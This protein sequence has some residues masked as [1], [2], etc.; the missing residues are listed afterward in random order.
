MKVTLFTSN[1]NR[2]NYFI[3]L[4]SN[5][6]D[7]LWVVQEVK[8]LFTGN[9]DSLYQN[10][11][12]IKS[13]FENVREVQ[14]KIFE[15]QHINN[16]AKNIKTLP[17]LNG[18]LSK[19]SIFYLKEF[20]ESNLYI[21][22]GSSYIKGNL[23]DFLVANKAINIHAGISPFYRGTDC[24]FWALYDNNPHLVGTTIHLLSKGLDSGAILYHAISD[25]K[26]NPYEYSMSSL[27]AAFHS[28]VKRIKD[29]SIFKIKPINQDKSKEIRYTRKHEFNE[30]IVKDYLSKKI[31]L[32]SKPFDNSL[33]KEPF[34]LKN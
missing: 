6:C 5:F 14:D 10:S 33:L 15:K 19:L 20:L 34:L 7:E 23:L 32:K 12:I 16:G 28:I 27:K 30:I 24:N 1:N 31:D 4:L 21:V 11:E 3:N 25:Q 26:I 9:N 29:K 8:T 13:Y 18:E 2:H 17:I 22:Y